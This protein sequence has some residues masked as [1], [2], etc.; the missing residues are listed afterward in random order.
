VPF[1]PVHL[2]LTSA[3]PDRLKRRIVQNLQPDRWL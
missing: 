1:V 2:N 3:L